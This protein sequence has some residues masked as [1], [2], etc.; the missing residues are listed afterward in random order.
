MACLL[1]KA[2]L[3]IEEVRTIE[4]APVIS[5]DRRMILVVALFICD[6]LPSAD[7]F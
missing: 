6:C 7:S 2:L 1:A 5:G 4:I 3:M